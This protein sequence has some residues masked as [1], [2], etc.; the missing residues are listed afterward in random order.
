MESSIL[1]IV[2]TKSD[3]KKE[4]MVSNREIFRFARECEVSYIETSSKDNFNI[5]QAVEQIVSLVV[6][7]TFKYSH[8]LCKIDIQS[9]QKV[10]SFFNDI[11]FSIYLN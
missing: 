3:L 9:F 10:K 5:D 2:G 7:D 4:R 11:H 1:I 6:F 8:F